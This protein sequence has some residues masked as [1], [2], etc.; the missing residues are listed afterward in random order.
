MSGEETGMQT[1]T[2][3]VV[4]KMRV[5]RDE[6]GKKVFIPKDYLS[7][8]QVTLMF[9]KL[10]AQKKKKQLREPIKQTTKND[11]QE[12]TVKQKKLMMEVN[13]FEVEGRGR[14]HGYSELPGTFKKSG[15]SSAI[16][17]RPCWAKKSKGSN[18]VYSSQHFVGQV[19]QMEEDEVEIEYTRTSGSSFVW[20]EVEDIGQTSK[21]IYF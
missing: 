14:K 17:F 5:L 7:V 10:A 4:P 18:Q 11:N 12:K 21:D 15:K 20:P 9:S 8:D 13:E 16:R 2:E 1:S 3:K 6:S 19:I